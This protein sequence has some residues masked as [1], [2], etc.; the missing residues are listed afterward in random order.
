MI[1]FCFSFPET[2]AKVSPDSG[3]KEG[4]IVEVITA[5]MRERI[6]RIAL[7]ITITAFMCCAYVSALFDLD[8]GIAEK[9]YKASSRF[10]DKSGLNHPLTNY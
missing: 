3:L 5:G 9:F 2:L 1:L 8:G 6:Y 10:F 4:K 7:P